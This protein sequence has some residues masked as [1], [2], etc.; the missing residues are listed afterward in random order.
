MLEDHEVCR[1]PEEFA[2]S[3]P[4]AAAQTGDPQEML[5][6]GGPDV[7]A[8]EALSRLA[9]ELGLGAYAHSIEGLKSELQKIV[10][11]LHPDKS[12]GEFK[13]DRDKARFMKARRAIELLNSDSSAHAPAVATRL[14]GAPRAITDTSAPATSPDN[15]NRLQVSLFADARQ[16]IARYFAAPKIVASVL[17]ASLLVLVLTAD[18]FERNPLL[19]PLFDEA[20]VVMLVAVLAFAAALAAAALCVCERAA[21][22]HA[23][24]LLSEAAL[25]ELFEQARRSAHRQGRTAQLSAFDLRRGTDVL[26][27][28]HGAYGAPRRRRL[29]RRS[30][31]ATTRDCITLIQTK[32][33]LARRVIRLVDRPAL[34]VLYEVSPRAMRETFR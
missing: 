17:A 30:L 14:A 5:L 2:L 19:G 34:E 22:S 25:G 29:L 11:A 13:S 18:R 31:D 7:V 12:G 32:R 24:H 33:L 15:E 10:L 1:R 4:G 16:R 26:A 27:D 21:V 9:R 28:G 8:V 20:A 3:V 23:E 6:A